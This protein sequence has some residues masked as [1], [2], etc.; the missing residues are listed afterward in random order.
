MDEAARRTVSVKG[1]KTA[2]KIR[3]ARGIRREASIVGRFRGI[4]KAEVLMNTAA[5]PSL[6][7]GMDGEDIAMVTYAHQIGK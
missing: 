3:P 1:P 7:S 4:I 5:S 6:E 2:P